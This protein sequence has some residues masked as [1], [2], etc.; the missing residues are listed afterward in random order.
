M[1]MKAFL[2]KVADTRGSEAREMWGLNVILVCLLGPSC[3]QPQSVEFSVHWALECV[4]PPV[5]RVRETQGHDLPIWELIL[6]WAVFLYICAKPLPSALLSPLEILSSLVIFS[7]QPVETLSIFKKKKCLK[8]CCLFFP[9]NVQRPANHQNGLW[10][11]IQYD[12][13][14]QREPLFLR[15]PWI[16]SAGYARTFLKSSVM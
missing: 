16:R 9:D 14:L 4:R 15:V 7:H 1:L 10:G 12:N 5:L 11:G 8:V 13:G 2:F 6:Y 3:P